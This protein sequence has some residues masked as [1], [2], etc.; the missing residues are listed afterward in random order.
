MNNQNWRAELIDNLRIIFNN[1]QNVI[2]FS[3]FGSLTNK[4]NVDQWSDI[5]ALL[6]IDL[7]GINKYYPSTTWIEKLGNIFTIQ[8]SKNLN[9]GT[10]KIIFDDF[11]K[12]DLIIATDEDILSDKIQLSK[13][14]IVFSK[15]D[16]I[17]Q[18]LNSINTSNNFDINSYNIEK[19]ASEFWF[20]SYTAITKI[21]RNDLLIGL[22][23]ALDL[24]RYCLIL[25]MWL[26]D[27]KTGTNIH[28][29]G[30]SN[31]ELI[32][33]MNLKLDDLSKSGILN[34]I[35]KCGEEFDKLAYQWSP[36]YI[37][38]SSQIESLINKAISS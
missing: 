24:Y 13:Q 20:L 14:E 11:R 27:K 35:K 6:V 12:I 38:K 7:N 21:V 33:Q 4:D 2:S 31:N 22:H 32:S 23:L 29:L 36:N 17:T 1:D 28:R 16:K 25:A 10:T 3:I 30:G 26:R 5:D 19:L 34:F 8:Q 18:K 15:S 37:K 9:G